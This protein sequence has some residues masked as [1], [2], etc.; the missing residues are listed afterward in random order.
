M[1]KTENPKRYDLKERTA[2]FAKRVGAFVEGLPKT[3][4]N[5]E[6][7]KQL[8]KASGSVGVNYIE[9]NEAL[10]MKVFGAILKKSQ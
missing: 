8:M 4:T 2:K 1:S 3:M 7:G 5:L 9:A 10:R 6:Y